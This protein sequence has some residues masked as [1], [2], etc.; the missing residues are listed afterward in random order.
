MLPSVENTCPSVKVNMSVV[1]SAKKCVEIETFGNG[2]SRSIRHFGNPRSVFGAE[3]IIDRILENTSARVRFMC[4]NGISYE[5]YIDGNDTSGIQ[6]VV[7][8]ESTQ[9]EKVNPLFTLARLEFFGRGFKMGS[10]F[11]FW[12]TW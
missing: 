5:V 11:Q 6:R 2:Q 9:V 7:F 4:A 10:K 12:W 3:I 8:D 1:S